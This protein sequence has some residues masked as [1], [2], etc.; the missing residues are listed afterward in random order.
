MLAKRYA[1]SR[2]ILSFYAALAE[3]QGDAAARALSPGQ[4]LPELADLVQRIGPPDLAQA[5]RRIVTL[6]DLGSPPPLSFFAL[7]ARQPTAA[8]SG[9]HRAPQAGCLMPAGE[10]QALEL[11]CSLCLERWPFPRS[12]CPTCGESRE[13]RLAFYSAPEIPQ[14][15]LQACETCRTYLPL[16]DLLRDP[17][18][19]P[20]V[21]ELAGLPL[22]LW[23]QEHGYHKLHP[24]LAGV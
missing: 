4:A 18:A 10:G 20:E 16:A 9:S 3:W 19:I 14:L 24:N 13:G 22:D 21:D 12:R 6:P 1:A 5:A 2:E 11:V 8:C 17:E 15:R 23:A 7:A